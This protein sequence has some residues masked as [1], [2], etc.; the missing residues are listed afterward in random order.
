M[1]HTYLG[2]VEDHIL[3]LSSNLEQLISSADQLTNLIF[4]TMGAYQNESM[5]QLTLVTIFFLPLTF[6]TGYFGQNFEAMWSVQHNSDALF[7]YI[8]IP[9]QIVIVMYLMRGMI[10]RL[11]R[12]LEVKLWVRRRKKARQTEYKGFQQRAK[13]AK[14]LGGLDGKGAVGGKMNGNGYV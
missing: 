7:W 12:R 4:N 14:D 2:D 9:V 13:A 3:T 8:A 10:R 6:L 11:G 1:A 5:K